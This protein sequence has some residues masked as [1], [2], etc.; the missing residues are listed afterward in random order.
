MS[1]SQDHYEN[2]LAE[3]YS[4]MFGDYRAKVRENIDFF[5][6]YKILPRVNGRAIDLGVRQWISVG[7]SGRVGL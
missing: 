4:W 2:L 6:G 5:K 7:G 1:H 3:H